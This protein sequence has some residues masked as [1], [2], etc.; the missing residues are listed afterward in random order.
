MKYLN[1]LPKVSPVYV[2][3]S[4][5]DSIYEVIEYGEVLAHI[6]ETIDGTRQNLYFPD[7]SEIH[8][9]YHELEDIMNR[10]VESKTDFQ[11]AW[12][13][14]EENG[15]VVIADEGN[16][17]LEVEVFNIDRTDMIFVGVSKLDIEW[18][19]HLWKKQ[20]DVSSAFGRRK[21]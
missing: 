10:Y 2:I 19:A 18:R 12:K 8:F 4:E 3:S 7:G 5:D 14:F 16:G 1:K 11:M 17:F 20:R 21:G 9:D 13:W 6:V 15:Y